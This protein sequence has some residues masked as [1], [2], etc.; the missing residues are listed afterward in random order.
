MT[1]NVAG[2]EQAKL[3][4]LNGSHSTLAYAGLLRGHTSVADA[5]GDAT[6]AG[7]IDAMIRDDIIPTL[8]PVA[9]FDLDGYR[10][11]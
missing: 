8:P 7:F 11:A 6:L 1:D 2:Y 5:M 10:S 9:G 4:I 3:R